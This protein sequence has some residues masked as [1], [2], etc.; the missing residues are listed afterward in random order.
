LRREA[1]A[2]FAPAADAGQHITLRAAIEALIDHSKH[3]VSFENSLSADVVF[4]R[5]D[6]EE[7][8]RKLRSLNEF[9]T[10]RRKAKKR[11]A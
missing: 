5:G 4:G 7:L 2:G 9:M 3:V 8:I 6:L 10:G 11:A 1:N